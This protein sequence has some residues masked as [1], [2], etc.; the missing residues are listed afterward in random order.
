MI[1]GLNW[2]EFLDC[3]NHEEFDGSWTIFQRDE[4]FIQFIGRSNSFFIEEE[5][6]NSKLVIFSLDLLI[7]DFKEERDLI[8]LWNFSVGKFIC[9]KI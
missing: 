7:L 6:C 9:V 2:K 8:F 5:E 4:R 1:F 3:E